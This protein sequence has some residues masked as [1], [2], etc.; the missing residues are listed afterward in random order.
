MRGVF[1]VLLVCALAATAPVGFAQ[2]PPNRPVEPSDLKIE[3]TEVALDVIV[4]DQKGRPVTNLDASDITVLEDGVPQDI[5]SFRLVSPERSDD[6]PSKKEA[7]STPATPVE[8][9]SDWKGLTSAPEDMK[10][11]ALVFDRLDP[12]ARALAY[13]AAKQYVDNNIR[14]GD[15]VGVYYIDLS[16]HS[17]QTYTTDKALIKNAVEVA[18]G[19]A[20]ATFKASGDQVLK[21]KGSSGTAPSFDVEAASP[22]IGGSSTG[23]ASNGDDI[24]RNMK[25]RSLEEFRDLDMLQEGFAT[26]RSLLA[27]TQGLKMLPGRKAI[28]FFSTGIALPQNVERSFEAVINHANAAHVSIYPIDAAG[29]RVSAPWSETANEISSVSGQRMAE[30][31]TPNEGNMR[32]MTQGYERVE[33]AV[34]SA[35]HWG[36][37]RLAKETGGYL[38]ADTNDLNAKMDQIEEDLHTYYVLTYNPKN[39]NYD[40]SF[41]KIAVTTRKSSLSVQTREGYYAINIPDAPPVLPYEAQAVAAAVKKAPP[42]D[43]P[44]QTLATNFPDPERP[45]LTPVLVSI[46]PGAVT[47][48]KNEEKKTFVTEFSVVV[49]VRDASRKIVA[50]RSKEYVLVGPLEDLPKV[51]KNGLLYYGE[52]DLDPGRYT[53][54]VAAYDAPS[55]KAS[56]RR[57]SLHVVPAESDLRMSSVAIVERAEESKAA[58][59]D[60]ANPF[61]VGKTLLYPNLGTPLKKGTDKK[62]AFFTTVYVPDGS[63][64]TPKATLEVTRNG[65]SLARMPVDLPSPDAHGRIQY[66]NAVSVE[67]FP[68]GTYLL[69]LTVDDGTR[70]VTRGTRFSVTL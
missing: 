31:G 5:T 65:R 10:A 37:G 64:R 25:I 14:P 6:K 57:S 1:I 3:T 54:D 17:V 7:T 68:P 11:I 56:V 41:R 16:L 34:R 15:A 24:L 38:I 13:K 18:G 8:A 26:T 69:R 12:P 35:P 70:T 67:A 62:L 42:A 23:Q 51:Q 28:L 66:T 33:R 20:T 32:S 19:A 45:G 22:T 44:I 50:K 2:N 43:F 46:P 53:V 36:L 47:F 39:E 61:R 30:L 63:T 55:Q 58:A 40:G 9:T 21:L 60:P 27:I 4:K 49:L 59:T 48:V 52:L 29:L